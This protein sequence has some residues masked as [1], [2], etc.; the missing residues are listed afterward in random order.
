M[1][2]SVLIIILLGSFLI[3]GVACRKKASVPTPPPDYFRQAETH[4]LAGE[5]GPAAR[6]Y[7]AYIRH[8]PYGAKRD[9]ALFNI[10]MA[11][12]IAE[13][14]LYDRGKAREGF[15]HLKEM[16]PH[17]PFTREAEVILGLS[18]QVERLRRTAD[19][20]QR[21][22]EFLSSQIDLLRTDLGKKETSVSDR[23]HQIRALNGELERLE[24]EVKRLRVALSGREK[25][26]TSLTNELEQLKR[27]DMQRRPSQ[28]PRR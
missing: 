14:P 12:A 20:Q 25:R 22:I 15:Q 28:P 21:R 27:I 4:F 8:N 11:H 5:Y 2:R 13:S 9:R 7:E 19:E 17:S 16:F 3:S 24:R 18:R 26:I 23:E 10:A 6:A 1:K